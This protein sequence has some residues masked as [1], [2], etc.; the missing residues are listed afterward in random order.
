MFTMFITLF[1]WDP[2]LDGF[3][4]SLA[5]D[6]LCW[7]QYPHLRLKGGTPFVDISRLLTTGLTN[8]INDDESL[9]FNNCTNLLV[10][11]KV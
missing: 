1:M 2:E 7:A 8:D 11:S 9:R 4:V 10:V 3:V 6:H 5:N